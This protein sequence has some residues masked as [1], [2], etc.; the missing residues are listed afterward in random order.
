YYLIFSDNLFTRNNPQ[1]S[2]EPILYYVVFKINGN[3]VNI[4]ID[5]IDANNSPMGHSKRITI[6]C[7]INKDQARYFSN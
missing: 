6:A 1:Y 7:Q 3:N 2:N 4:T 5:I